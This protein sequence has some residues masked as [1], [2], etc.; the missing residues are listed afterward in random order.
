MSHC[1]FH[2]LSVDCLNVSLSCRFNEYHRLSNVV[3]GFLTTKNCHSLCFGEFKGISPKF[4]L[5]AHFNPAQV[6]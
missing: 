4:K 6:T 1:C 3:G 5:A 2:C